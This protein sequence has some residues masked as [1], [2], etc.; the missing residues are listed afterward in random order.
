MLPEWLLTPMTITYVPKN[1]IA[2][3]QLLTAVHFPRLLLL[4]WGVSV[5]I[6]CILGILKLSFFWK[7]L[8]VHVFINIISVP[9]LLQIY[10]TIIYIQSLVYWA[11]TKLYSTQQIYSQHRPGV[12]APGSPNF[13]SYDNP[14]GAASAQANK[15][16]LNGNFFLRH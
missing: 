16:A 9:C 8:Y 12:G 13:P 11:C 4:K 1:W 14:L 5:R 6:S 10:I 3:G 2:N 7:G 15:R